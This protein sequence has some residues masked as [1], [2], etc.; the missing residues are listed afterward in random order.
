LPRLQRFQFPDNGSQ[1]IEGLA[2]EV[3]LSA[4]CQQFARGEDMVSMFCR[5]DVGITVA[6]IYHPVAL[7]QE[8]PDV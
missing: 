2:I 3:V 6:N 5:Y 1:V 4:V 7:F 8:K